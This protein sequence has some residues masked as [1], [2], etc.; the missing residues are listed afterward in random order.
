MAS[1]LKTDYTLG[2]HK[3]CVLRRHKDKKFT[4]GC[5][6]DKDRYP[7]TDFSF[8]LPYG[9][10]KQASK[11]FGKAMKIIKK[12]KGQFNEKTMETLEDSLNLQFVPTDDMIGYE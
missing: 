8:M 3:M 5:G 2:K 11:L 7:G 12:R 10:P 9:T 6:S 1:Y 4:I